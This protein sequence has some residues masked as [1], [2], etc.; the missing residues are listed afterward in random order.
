M[1]THTPGAN[2]EG[3]ELPLVTDLSGLAVLVSDPHPLYLRY[4]DGPEQD[5][6]AVSKDYESGLSMSGLSVTTLTPEPWWTHPVEDW[7]A[8]QVRKYAPLAE[9]EPERYGWVLRGR[10][11]ARGPDHEPLVDRFQPIARLADTVMD[12]ALESYRAR[13]EAGRGPTDD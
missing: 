13:F 12:E 7:L 5:R 2:A 1:T 11:V 10:L 4:S 9:R 8:R 3:A 6:E